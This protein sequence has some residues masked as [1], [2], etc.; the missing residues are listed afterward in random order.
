MVINKGFYLSTKQPFLLPKPL[1]RLGL[2]IYLLQQ[3]LIINHL[4]N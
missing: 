2:R 1:A 4:K 3:E